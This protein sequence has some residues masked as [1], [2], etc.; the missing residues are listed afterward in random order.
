MLQALSS[1]LDSKLDAKMSSFSQEF[2]SLRNHVD[3]IGQQLEV[4]GNKVE[5]LEA[6]A[7]GD[8]FEEEEY[9]EEGDIVQDEEQSLYDDAVATSAQE[10]QRPPRMSRRS[11]Q[12]VLANHGRGPSKKTKT[13]E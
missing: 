1:L 2:G 13:G 11:A 7:E 12:A 4:L 8:D 3:F 6:C 5:C 9:D 10:P